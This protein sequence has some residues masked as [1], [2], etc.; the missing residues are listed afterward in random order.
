MN[1]YQRFH[2]DERTHP[3]DELIHP[4]LAKY[5]GPALLAHNNAI[6]RKSDFESLKRLGDSLKMQ[7]GLTTGKFGRGFNSVGA[8]F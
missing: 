2:L 3:T 8:V 5:Q 7:D 6:F 1:K 4:A